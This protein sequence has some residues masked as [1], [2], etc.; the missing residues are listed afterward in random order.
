M[1]TEQQFVGALE[2]LAVI[3]RS[4]Q[5]NA[6]FSVG[7]YPIQL[8]VLQLCAA[9]RGKGL[10]PTALAA[11]LNVTAPSL[12]DTLRTL[13]KKGLIERHPH[14]HDGR[15]VTIELSERGRVLLEQIAQW[16]TPLRSAIASLPLAKREIAYEF[17][18][19]LLRQLYHDGI[20]TIPHMCLTCRWFHYDEHRHTTPYYCQLLQT[21]LLPLQLRFECPDHE[22]LAS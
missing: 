7:L 12:S 13:E 11:E 14:P 17:I 19:E 2:R 9:R 3:I 22:P 21:E 1:D 4:L 8:Q 6:A 20:I 18:I 10:T 5:W 16:D 15:A